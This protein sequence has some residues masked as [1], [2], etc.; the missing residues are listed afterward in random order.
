MSHRHVPIILALLFS[1]QLVGQEN[2][3]TQR[4]RKQ[5]EQF[6]ENVFKVAENVYT[7]VG[8][9]VSNVS[10]VVGADGVVIV[11][12]GMMSDAAERIAQ[13]FRKLTDKPVK[14]II[15]THSPGDHT[16]VL[17]RSWEKSVRKSGHT[18]TSAARHVRGERAD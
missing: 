6:E 8:Y 12:T 11:D 10:M 4:L 9:S 16:G 18:R 2:A 17:L 7:A 15:Y 13:E 14:A 3:S 1:S 5:S